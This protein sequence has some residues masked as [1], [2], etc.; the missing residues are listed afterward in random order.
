MTTSKQH[1]DIRADEASG[2]EEEAEEE[3][4]SEAAQ[5][6]SRLIY[7]VIR[8]DGEEELSR[9]MSSLVYSGLTAGVLMSFSVIGEAV[10]RAHLPDR[11]WRPLV[12]NLGY[13]FGF[14]LVIHG[15]MQL[16]TENT[17]TTVLPLLARFS[18]MHIHGT[19]RLW[20]TVLVANV[21]GAFVSAGF[22]LWTGAFSAELQ[23]AVRAISLHAMD[24]GVVEGFF[25]AMPAG[26][27]VAAIVWIMPTMPHGSFWAIVAFTWLISAGD[28][29]HIVAGSVEMAFLMLSGELDPVAG[30]GR[31]FLPVLLGNVAGGTMVFTMMAWGQVMNEVADNRRIAGNQA[32]SRGTE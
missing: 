9:P 19:I 20:T 1:R 11:E 17:I 7:E 22:M 23:A 6:S 10:F 15:R 32:G 18:K 12:E 29:A 27:L 4:V 16:F 24:M 25:R 3:S 2:V 5:L 13:T 30:F 14:L 31:F 26:V 28:F 8:R 21:V